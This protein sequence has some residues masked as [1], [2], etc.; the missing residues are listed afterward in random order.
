VVSSER[1]AWREVPLCEC[2]VGDLIAIAV[3]MGLMIVELLCTADRWSL[4]F[5]YNV[6]GYSIYRR[7][8]VVCTS[9]PK[10]MVRYKR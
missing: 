8:R 1:T 5:L 3:S 7:K 9:R 4:S 2:I 6:D 10:V